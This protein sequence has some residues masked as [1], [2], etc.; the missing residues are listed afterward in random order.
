M[1]DDAKLRLGSSVVTSLSR[2]LNYGPRIE[3]GVPRQGCRSRDSKIASWSASRVARPL[4]S[5]RRSSNSTLTQDLARVFTSATLFFPPPILVP[6]FLKRTN[7]F[8]VRV[9]RLIKR[10]RGLFRIPWFLSLSPFFFFFLPTRAL[11]FSSRGFRIDNPFVR[12]L[13]PSF[14]NSLIVPP[15][16]RFTDP[17]IPGGSDREGFLEGICFPPRR[18][19]VASFNHRDF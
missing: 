19:K 16:I 15:V 14:I 4:D 12:V 3:V 5:R 11:S 2:Y 17:K 1:D 8:A 18:G 9:D 10:R 6:S 13:L 7:I